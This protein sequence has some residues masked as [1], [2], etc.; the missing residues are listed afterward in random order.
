SCVRN[1]KSLKLDTSGYGSLLIPILKDR[2]PDEITMIIS[3]KFGE[4]IWTLDKVMEYFNSE[5]RAQE[6]CSASTSN[7]SI[8]K[9]SQR[10]GAYY[11]TSGLFG[12]TNKVACV[13]CGKEGHSSSKCS[14]VSNC[15]SRK[16]ILRRNKRCFI[17]LDTGHIAK[18]CKSHYLCRKC[19][20]GKHHISICEYTPA[21]P[22]GIN[23]EE[24]KNATT[25]DNKGFVVHANCDKSGILLQTARADILPTDDNVQ[26]Q[27]RIL[28][29]SGS[30]RSYI[31]D[32]VR[33]T[34]KLKA[35]RVEKV[36]IKT[37]G[38]AENSEVQELDIVQ[39]K[40]R[41]KGDARF[42]FVEALCV[43]TICS[44]LTH[45][46]LSSVH[47]LPEFAGLEFADFEHKQ[48]QNLPVGILIGIDFYHVFMTGKVIRSKLGPVACKTR[49]GWVLSGRIGSSTSDMH[50]FETHLLRAS[51]EQSE[52]DISL[53]QE[54]D[55]FWNVESI[56]TKTDSVVDQFENDIIHDGTRYITKLPFK[57]DHEVLPDNFKVCEG[58]LKSLKNKLAVS[59][60]LHEYNQIF[61]E[62]EE[63]GIIERVPSAEVARET[64]QVHYLPHRPVIRNDKQTTKIRAVFDASC[65][66]SGPSLNECL[67]SGPNLIAKIFDILLR[68]RLNKIGVLADIKQAFL[69][70][71]IDVQHR[72]YLRFLWYDLQA[73]DE[74]V[75]IYRFLRV[76]F[77]I[78]S[79]PFLLNGTIR[80]HLSNYLEKEREIAQRVKDDLYV[81]DL[82]SGCNKLE[83]GKALYDRSKA[84]LSE[85]G[86]NLRKWVTNDKELAGYIA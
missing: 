28:F 85:A 71:G 48:H 5:L 53:R 81:D 19:K 62:Y 41:N 69:N 67:Y 12:Q 65:K 27:T 13:Y 72:D 51:V 29:D 7:R 18:N 78:T 54:L 23:R 3:R 70:V 74:Q 30:Q 79:S 17:C 6:N 42:T 16:A 59:N 77:G 56:G 8:Q 36:V 10:K 64:G 58:R 80:R 20:T 61:S 86:F 46:P 63:N 9:E 68:F 40:V 60:I 83:E 22:P 57:P 73:E 35:I 15:Q 44:P 2:L 21:D 47:E 4:E 26:V 39:L 1:L 37:F 25:N 55:K 52:S 24:D 14:S 38:Q 76:V 31:S 43:P 50:C 11:T 34:L 84:I 32:K 45:Q 49:V 66:V 33:S 82:V 75:V